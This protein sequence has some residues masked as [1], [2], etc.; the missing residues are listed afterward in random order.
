[1]QDTSCQIRFT[2]LYHFPLQPS[3]NIMLESFP[4]GAGVSMALVLQAAPADA[5][6][7]D[8]RELK[9]E[10]SFLLV[11]PASLHQGESRHASLAGLTLHREGRAE[12]TK[13][14]MRRLTC[15]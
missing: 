1:M 10:S 5:G 8:H 3:Q 2:K 15:Y 7:G 11:C 13:V 9:K 14:G 12:G 6:G 4:F